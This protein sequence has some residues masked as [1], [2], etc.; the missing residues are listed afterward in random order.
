MVDVWSSRSIHL[1]RQMPYMEDLPLPIDE[2]KFLQWR[3][4]DVAPDH[5]EDFSSN[6]NAKPYTLPD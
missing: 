2:M 1:P 4:G 3:P 5:G 6:D